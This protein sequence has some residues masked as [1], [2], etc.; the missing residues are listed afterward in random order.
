MQQPTITIEGEVRNDMY[1]MFIEAAG[2][3]F[4]H[5]AFDT[6]FGK[7]VRVDGEILSWRS[8]SHANQTDLSVFIGK[9]TVTVG[10]S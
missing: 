3:R 8:E 2:I 4:R 5:A 10:K 9:M 6:F 1:G 7:F